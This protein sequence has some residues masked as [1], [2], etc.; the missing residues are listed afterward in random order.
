[1]HKNHTITDITFTK[2]KSLISAVGP[3]IGS[4]AN[5]ETTSLLKADDGDTAGRIKAIQGRT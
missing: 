3:L 1:M 4:G 5:G 2:G